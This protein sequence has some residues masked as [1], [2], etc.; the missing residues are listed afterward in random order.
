VVGMR[1]RSPGLGVDRLQP[2]DPHKTLNPFSVYSVAQPPQMI[3]HGA[4]APC[5]G[6]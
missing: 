3:S 2:H 5:G 6:L 1:T 4:A